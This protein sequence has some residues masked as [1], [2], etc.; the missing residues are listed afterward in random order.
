M[1][2][3]Q[4]DA[5]QPEPTPQE[6]NQN[7]VFPR[8]LTRLYENRTIE[9]DEMMLLG[10]IDAFHNLDKGGCFAT[11]FFFSKWWG[12]SESVVSRAITK[13]RRLGLLETKTIVIPYGTRRIMRV[14]YA[15]K[16]L[17]GVA[18][19]DQ[20]GVVKNSNRGVVK[21]SE[22]VQNTTY[23]VKKSTPCTTARK[24]RVAQEELGNFGVS[25]NTAN[26]EGDTPLSLVNRFI[27]FRFSRGWHKGCRRPNIP[28]W[29]RTITDLITLEG[30]QKVVNVM[31]WYFQNWN[32]KGVTTPHD[33]TTFCQ[34][35]TSLD[36]AMRWD[37]D[38]PDDEPEEKEIRRYTNKYGQRV[39]FEG[40]DAEW[41]AYWEKRNAEREKAAEEAPG[42]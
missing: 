42:Y 1:I 2:T 31:N 26:S 25:N 29:T 11:N 41:E 27:A 39:L 24:A 9:A 21:N 37:L 12:K 34:R 18:M 36:K 30:L 22:Q 14:T 5:G 35:F 19:G 38:I 8:C 4:T 33:L 32:K 6:Q 15:V 40:T 17:G 16:E 10:K 28:V 7:W 23:S 20:G 13:L 3:D